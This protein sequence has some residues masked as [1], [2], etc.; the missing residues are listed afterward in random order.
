MHWE[1][2]SVF[3]LQSRGKEL[4]AQTSQ[5]A[6]LTCTAAIRVVTP[7]S[8]GLLHSGFLTVLTA[9][10]GGAEDG[11]ILSV[12]ERVAISIHW[13]VEKREVPIEGEKGSG[14]AGLG[15]ALVHPS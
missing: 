11:G 9:P 3:S 6:V 14:R 5:L 12:V 7:V 10:H 13:M 2:G 15:L 8:Q 4:E 1:R